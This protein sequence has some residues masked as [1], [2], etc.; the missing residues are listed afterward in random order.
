MA[1]K[2]EKKRFICKI[3]ESEKSFSFSTHFF[4]LRP[5]RKKNILIQISII[6]NN[7]LSVYKSKDSDLISYITPIDWKDKTDK[8]LREYEEINFKIEF[9][10]ENVVNIIA[11]EG[12]KMIQETNKETVENLSCNDLKI[13]ELLDAMSPS[14]LRNKNFKNLSSIDGY[15]IGTT[16]DKSSFDNN[17]LDH[18][19]ENQKQCQ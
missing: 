8:Y 6:Y 9:N 1:R 5:P 4:Q 17:N 11:E 19:K 12:Y 18:K 10:Y 16:K 7:L 15:S 3:L 2:R 14:K 13:D